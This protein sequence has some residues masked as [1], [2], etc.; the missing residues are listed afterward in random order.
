MQRRWLVATPSPGQAQL[1]WS[2]CT[3][4]LVAAAVDTCSWGPALISS[5]IWH[6]MRS[7][8]GL[9]R[10]MGRRSNPPPGNGHL[11]SQQ[12]WQLQVVQHARTNT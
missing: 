12:S 10:A 7:Q 4:V 3:T 9:E 8:Q 6:Q 5:I 11:W 1:L 2:S